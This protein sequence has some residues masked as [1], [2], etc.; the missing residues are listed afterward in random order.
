MKGREIICYNCGEVTIDRTRNA[1]GKFCSVK[2]CRQYTNRHK[3]RAKKVEN[4]CVYN[5]SVVCVEH[6]CQKCG[7]NPQVETERKESLA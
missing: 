1:R 3:G 2:C 7:W 6:D 5:D 4:L